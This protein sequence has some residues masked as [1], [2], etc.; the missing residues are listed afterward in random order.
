MP[1]DPRRAHCASL[2]D[3]IARTTVHSEIALHALA[4]AQALDTPAAP[5]PAPVG[6]TDR[7]ALAEVLRLLAAMIADDG[8]DDLVEAVHHALLAHIAA[9][10]S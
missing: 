2:L 10:P 6:D 7:A 5:L 9:R 8:G 1:N 3:T 4:A